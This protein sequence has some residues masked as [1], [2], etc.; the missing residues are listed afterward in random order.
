MWCKA[1]FGLCGV[2]AL[3]AGGCSD[4]DEPES[5]ESGANQRAYVGGR[6]IPSPSA[7]PIE[8]G[9]VIVENERIIEVGSRTSV[10][11]PRAA[12]R[13]DCTGTTVLAGFWN[14]H[15]HFMPPAWDGAAATD[16]SALE[17]SLRAPRRCRAS[18]MEAP[19]W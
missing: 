3:L 2:I 4:A 5:P 14:S 13:I 6:V 7:L 18:W 1:H 11:I 19:M 8:D 16:A 12:R 15:V 9:V 17:S 10:R